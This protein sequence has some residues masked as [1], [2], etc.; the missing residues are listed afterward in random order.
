MAELFDRQDT[1]RRIEGASLRKRFAR[2]ARRR[3]ESLWLRKLQNQTR[4]IVPQAAA[5]RWASPRSLATRPSTDT[6]S[7]SA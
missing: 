3:K 4:G 1:L 7:E 2:Y 6:P 5:C